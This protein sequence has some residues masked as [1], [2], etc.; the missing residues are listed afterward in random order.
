M[1][2]GK[3]EGEKGGG[4]LGELSKKGGKRRFRQGAGSS[5]G[6]SGSSDSSHSS[7]R[8]PTGHDGAAQRCSTTSA[9]QRVQHNGAEHDSITMR[10]IDAQTNRPT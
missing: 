1:A 6:S 8:T 4:F 10:R 9:A 2:N 3:R 7:C 5:C